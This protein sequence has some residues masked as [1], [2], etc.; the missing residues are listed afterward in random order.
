MSFFE[1]L[2]ARESDALAGRGD[3]PRH[4]TEPLLGGPAVLDDEWLRN[5]AAVALVVACF[6]AGGRVA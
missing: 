3:D 6:A 5:S 1:P 2:L 4:Q